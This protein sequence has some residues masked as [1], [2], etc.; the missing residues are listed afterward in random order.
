MPILPTIKEEES[1]TWFQQV[2]HGRIQLLLTIPASL[3]LFAG[4]LKLAWTVYEAP[5][6]RFDYDYD[7]SLLIVALFVGGILG[8]IAASTFVGRVT[9]NIAHVSNEKE[10][11]ELIG[12]A[13]YMS[14]Y[15]TPQWCEFV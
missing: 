9:K 4:G 15:T 8:C 14:P 11:V 5:P 7:S 10:N 12:W 3:I 1:Q 6:N 13:A 2:W